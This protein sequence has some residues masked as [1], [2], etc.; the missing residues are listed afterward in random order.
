MLIIVVRI[1]E[2]YGGGSFF[3]L[4]ELLVVV[5]VVFYLCV[6]IFVCIMWF[7]LDICFLLG[8]Y[9]RKV[10]VCSC[11]YVR[12]IGIRFYMFVFF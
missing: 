12:I 9:S 4:L 1:V 8:I 2:L 6:F 7:G 10:D 3:G 5:F 11:I